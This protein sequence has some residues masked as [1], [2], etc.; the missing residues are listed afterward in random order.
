MEHLVNEI[1]APAT[2]GLS[3]ALFWSST[4]LPFFGTHAKFLAVD[5]LA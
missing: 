1:E 5:N 2:M 3:P 4:A